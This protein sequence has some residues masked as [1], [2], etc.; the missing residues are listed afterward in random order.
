[1]TK[2]VEVVEVSGKGRSPGVEAQESVAFATVEWSEE[3]MS[4]L[5]MDPVDKTSSG[6]V[7]GGVGYPDVP[8]SDAD[9]GRHPLRNCGLLQGGEGLLDDEVAIREGVKWKT[10]EVL[11]GLRDLR[12]VADVEAVSEGAKTEV[13]TCFP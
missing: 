11:D 10:R 8:C 1:M 3:M 7:G 12:G 6:A 5:S 2:H 13:R 4:F 9:R